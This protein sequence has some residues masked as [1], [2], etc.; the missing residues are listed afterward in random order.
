MRIAEYRMQN[1]IP[2][3]AIRIPNCKGGAWEA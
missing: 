2:K 1:K 3:S